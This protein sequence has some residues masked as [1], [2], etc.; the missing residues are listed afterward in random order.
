MTKE[1]KLPKGYSSKEEYVHSIFSTI[2]PK[3]D[4][5]NTVLSFNRDKVW[6]K[7]TVDKTGL[8]EGNRGIDVC[9]GTGELAFEQAKRVGSK[10]EVVGVDFCE[11]MLAIALEKTPEKYKNNIRW[12]KGDATNLPL[13][14]NEFDGATIGFALRNV[15]S[16]E[17]TIKEMKRVVKPGGKVVS[18]ELAKP[19]APVF[20]QLYYLYFNHLVPIMG[21][22]GIGKDGPYT[23]LPNSL[24]VFP[25]QD[26]IRDL[27][28]DVGLINPHY[29]ELTGGIVAVHVGTVP[30]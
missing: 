16:I 26:K 13:P 14:D 15:P 11:E 30:E 1:F 8:S 4:L 24:K 20:K 29:I 7:I 3:Y 23:Y 21:K 12:L 27:F 17:K 2:A 6:R 28:G 9:C 25:H 22:L 5:L 10:G 18:L 19:S